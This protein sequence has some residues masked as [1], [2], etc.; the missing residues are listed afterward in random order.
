MPSEIEKLAKDLKQ[1]PDEIEDSG[2]DTIKDELGT[3]KRRARANLRHNETNWQKDISDSIHVEKR[4]MGHALTVDATHGPYV[5]FG[6]GAYFGT[7]AYPV[8]A[9]VEAY[10]APGGVTEELVENIKHWMETKPVHPEYYNTIEQASEAIA[11]TIAE[12]G[13]Q[14]QPYLRPAWYGY[15]QSLIGAVKRDVVK[16]VQGM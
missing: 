4:P 1:L 13:T 3:V 7:S 5:E 8:P 2:R 6:T 16:T 11:H 9:D 15:R 10:D 14:A 12:L